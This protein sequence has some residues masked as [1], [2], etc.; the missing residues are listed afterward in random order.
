MQRYSL[1][2][3]LLLSLLASL[4]TVL[5]TACGSGRSPNEVLYWTADSGTIDAEA[6]QQIV[7]AFNKANPDIHVHMVKVYGSI[8]D[9]SQLVTSVRGGTGPDVYWLDRFTVS[10]FAAL[11]LLQPLDSFLVRDPQPVSQLYLPFAWDETQF[12][13]HTY[14]LPMETDVRVLYYNKD[15]LKAAGVDPS[16]M[17]PAHG[18]ITVDQLKDIAFKI[19][20]KAA[21]GA[22]DRLGFIPWDHNSEDEVETWG[23]D[24]GAHFINRQ[25]CQITPTEPAMVKAMQLYADWAKALNPLKV[26]AFIDTYQPVNAPPTQ[27]YFYNG[28]LAMQINGN[29][30]LSSLEQYAPH[31]N[32]GMTYLPVL[33]GHTPFTWSGGN[34]LVMPVN[35]H[36]PAGAYRF[37]RFFTGP[38]GQRIYY[39]VTEHLPT[40][41]A[42]LQDQNLFSPGDRFFVQMLPYAHNRPP[43]PVW[44]A[45][46][47]EFT[48]ASNAVVAGAA[49]P[50]QALQNVYNR[51]QPELQ[52]FCPL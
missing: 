10:Q 28:R 23:L 24:F 47:N 37:M 35:A 34:S 4:L 38:V 22:Y 14:A 8:S 1:R 29:W 2:V 19:N 15:M 3:V 17:N 26:Q 27:N 50:Q 13:G 51:V 11:G 18:P 46:W 33:S 20:H 9:I 30:Q 39:K 43:M 41:K 6:Q 21:N 45:L 52:P 25:T 32:W 5:L 12:Q 36:N 44:S 7:D 40:Y 42:L 48:D 31:L 49:T 16:I